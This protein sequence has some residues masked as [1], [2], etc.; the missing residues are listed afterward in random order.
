MIFELALYG[1]GGR[2]YERTAYS[3]KQEKHRDFGIEVHFQ[4]PSDLKR[5]TAFTRRVERLQSL[6][7]RYIYPRQLQ[8]EMKR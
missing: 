3:A 5:R 1:T 8:S 7:S 6:A 2:N 4:L